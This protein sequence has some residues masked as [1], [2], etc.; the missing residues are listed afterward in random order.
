MNTNLARFEKVKQNKK[1]YFKTFLRSPIGFFSPL[2]PA[3]VRSLFDARLQ[4]KQLRY[5][6]TIE[7]NALH[8]LSETLFPNLDLEE[9][10]SLGDFLED[11]R[12]KNLKDSSKVKLLDDLL[13]SSDKSTAHNYHYVYQIIIQDLLKRK[14]G[15]SI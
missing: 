13:K 7:W 8:K 12:I 11:V 2:M 1:K 5:K 15:I 14:M 9:S 3:K 6:K 10:I 4:D